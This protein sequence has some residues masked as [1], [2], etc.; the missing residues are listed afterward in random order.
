MPGG[1]LLQE[2]PRSQ[3][4]LEDGRDRRVQE[5]LHL[6]MERRPDP[7]AEDTDERRALEVAEHLE[8]VR[9]ERSRRERQGHFFP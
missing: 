7:E 4:A 1:D 9:G 3:L 2:V 8:R 5:A 6:A